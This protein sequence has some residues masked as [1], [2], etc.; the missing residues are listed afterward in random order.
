MKKCSHEKSLKQHLLHRHSHQWKDVCDLAVSRLIADKI[1]L[2]PK[3]IQIAKTNLKRWKKH[4]RPW[5]PAFRE[6]EQILAHNSTEGALAILTQDDDEGQRLRQ[7][8]PFVGILT[9]EERLR[10][11]DR[12]EES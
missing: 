2:Q 7:S 10:F 11:L 12:Y 6:W 3:L 1:R 4:L 5:P 8:D 9:E